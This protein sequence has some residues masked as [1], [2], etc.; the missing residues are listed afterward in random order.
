MSSKSGSAN[1][2]I[3]RT[4]PV[5]TRSFGMSDGSRVTPGA[6]PPSTRE[7]RNPPPRTTSHVPHARENESIRGLS[8]NGTS[9]ASPYFLSRIG[10]TS[11]RYQPPVTWSVWFAR[12]R[13]VG[14]K[15]SVSCCH[16]CSRRVRLKRAGTKLIDERLQP[17]LL[18]PGAVAPATG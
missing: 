7:G 11:W 15:S 8:P 2:K 4:H 9:V 1:V 10:G 12:V 17:E 13:R 5:P 6:G 16:L 14:G 18:Q 3:G